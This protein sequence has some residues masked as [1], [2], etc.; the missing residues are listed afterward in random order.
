MKVPLPVPI[1]GFPVGGQIG[2]QQRQLIRQRL[3]HAAPRAGM[4]KRAVNS[5][6]LPRTMPELPS[7]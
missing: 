4:G 3:A 6:C 7:V 5:Q 1:G 2:A